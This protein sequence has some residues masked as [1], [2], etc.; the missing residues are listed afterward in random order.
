MDVELV[1]VSGHTTT[2]FSIVTVDDDI[3]EYT[4]L[5]DITITR[6]LTTGAISLQVIGQN[7]S[8]IQINNND[9]NRF[10]LFYAY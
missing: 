5:L 9:G 4:E 1:L 2:S 6:V 7:S 10:P 3:V 8:N